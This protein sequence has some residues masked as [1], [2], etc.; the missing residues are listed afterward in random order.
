MARLQIPVVVIPANATPAIDLGVEGVLLNDKATLGGPDGD[1][2]YFLNPGGRTV[3]L[4]L[5]DDP[6]KS[7]GT[8]TLD[9]IPIAGDTMTI[10]VTGGVKVYTFRALVDWDAN[11]EIAIGTTLA[12]TQANIVA[13][14]NGTDG[15]NTAHTQV[16]AE[17]FNDEN[18]SII[19]AID[20]GTAGDTIATTETFTAGTNVFDAATLG[21][22]SAG[23]AVGAVTVKV[24]GVDDPYGRGASPAGDLTY[25]LTTGD[26]ERRPYVL[27]RYSPVM[28]NQSGASARR[29]HVDVSA[30]TG[31]GKLVAVG[32]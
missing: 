13:A 21:T 24:I 9:T 15:I 29:V 16:T 25:T 12:A 31:T 18:K 20:P 11:G 2:Y 4:C 7:Q 27:G 6:G 23:G 10:G 14:I 1:G 17:T 5:L 26:L 3:L 8:L 30:L 22:T 28:F 32:I 19:T